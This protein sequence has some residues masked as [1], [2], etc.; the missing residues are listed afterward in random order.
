VL[1]AGMGSRFGGIKQLASVGPKGETLLE[2]DLYDA[3]EAGFGSVVFLIRKEIEE[4]FRASILARLPK[5][6]PVELAYQSIARIPEDLLPGLG[7][8]GRAKPWGTG[9]ALLCAENFLAGQSFGVINAD[10]FYGKKGFRAVADFLAAA[11]KGAG[12]P[13][14]QAPEAASGVSRFCLAGYRLG[15]VLP[16]AGSVSRAIC[17]LGP[18]GS[19]AEIV[20]HT[21]IKRRGDEILSMGAD[22]TETRL[23]PDS[24]ASMNLWGLDD[25]VFP[26]ARRLFREFLAVKANWSEGEFYLP[27]VIGAMVKAGGAKVQ[28]LPVRER[29]FGLTNPEDL[30]STR[31]ILAQRTVAGDYPSPL[32]G[33]KTEGGPRP[34]REEA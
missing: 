1:A 20:E 34:E 30:A 22:G 18:D 10:D 21:R 33:G 17:G 27:F 3:R 29:L 23:S 5:D 32:W 15:G 19:L 6:L 16:S 24:L 8:S 11:G 9:H 14:A 25:S 4:D 26:A 12:G 28:A 13:T 2:Y 31:E 7:P